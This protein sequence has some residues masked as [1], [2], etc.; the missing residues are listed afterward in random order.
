M[1][2]SNKMFVDILGL[3]ELWLSAQAAQAPSFGKRAATGAISSK[4]SATIPRCLSSQQPAV[5]RRLALI[6]S[7]LI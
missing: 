7:D 3:F 2:T 6:Q 1:H 5:P 4:F